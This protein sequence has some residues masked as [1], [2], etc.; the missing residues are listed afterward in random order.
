MTF[1]VD[2]VTLEQVLLRVLWFSPVN[3]IPPL[4][5]VLLYHLEDEQ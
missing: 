5:S 1:V 2:K 4:L 3:N